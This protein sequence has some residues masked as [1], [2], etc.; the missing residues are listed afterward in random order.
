MRRLAASRVERVVLLRGT[1]AAEAQGQ[2]L[3]ANVILRSDVGGSGNASLTLSRTGDGRLSPSARISHSRR[4]A[5]WQSSIELS[6]E[7][8]RFPTDGVYLD[9]DADGGLVSTRRETIAAKAPE[10]GL[11][12]S[13]SVRWRGAR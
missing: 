4:I 8:E 7:V 6:G 5:G 9:R 3:V 2:M 12:L 11:A 10:Y 13:T 1:D